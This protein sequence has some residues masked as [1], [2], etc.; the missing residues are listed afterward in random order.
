MGPKFDLHGLKREKFRLSE[1]E[2]HFLG[3][4]D[5]SRISTDYATPDPDAC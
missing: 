1:I 3:R 5:R 4:S 2:P